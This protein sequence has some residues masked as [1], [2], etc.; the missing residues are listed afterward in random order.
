MHNKLS[1]YRICSQ[2]LD[3]FS[4]RANLSSPPAS[5]RPLTVPP[6]LT[7]VLTKCQDFL[8]DPLIHS[9]QTAPPLRVTLLL[10]PFTPPRRRPCPPLVKH[11]LTSLF[12]II[13]DNVNLVGKSSAGGLPLLGEGLRPS[14]RLSPCVTLHLAFLPLDRL[15]IGRI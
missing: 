8:Q 5:R 13:S 4:R 3:W 14:L 11:D 6:H 10:L 7:P 9:R 1:S 15:L 12:M 2:A